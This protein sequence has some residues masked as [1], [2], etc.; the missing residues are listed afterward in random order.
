MVVFGCLL[1]II[2]PLAGFVIGSY[3][4]DVAV[5]IWA[6]LGGFGLAVLACSISVTALVKARNR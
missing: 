1:L 2:L 6:A 3:F 4:G 5:G